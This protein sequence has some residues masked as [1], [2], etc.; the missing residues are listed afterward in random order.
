VINDKREAVIAEIVKV[1]A[2]AKARGEDEMKAA[3]ATFPG[4]PEWVL[5]DALI[6]A[7]ADEVEK[8]WESVERTID[9]ELVRRA[10][11]SAHEGGG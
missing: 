2:A 4:A 8:W 10:I 3:R 1:M 11:A 5:L 7:E 6:R 9:G